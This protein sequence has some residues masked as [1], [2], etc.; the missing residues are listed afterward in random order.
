MPLAGGFLKPEDF[1]AEMRIPLELFVCE[2]C[3]LAQICHVVD[4]DIL[5]RNY[6]YVS[7]VIRSL[8]E[9]FREYAEFLRSSYFSEPAS[10]LL[11]M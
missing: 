6:F 7:S 4:P 9:H 11:E 2:N 5:F 10:K 3:K 1:S 8:S